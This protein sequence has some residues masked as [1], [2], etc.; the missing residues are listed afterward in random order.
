MRRLWRPRFCSNPAKTS[1]V[2]TGRGGYP[3]GVTRWWR[4]RFGADL[5]GELAQLAALLVVYKAVRFWS[6][7]H[8]SVAV[9]NARH[10]IRLEQRLRVSNE[11]DLTKVSMRL[12]ALVRFFNQY[13][14]LAHFA[15]TLV[16]M[17]WLYARRPDAYPLCRRI[18]I[19]MTA[20]GLVLHIAYPLAP[21]RMF[22]EF[23]FIDTGRL[24]GPR[25]YGAHGLFNGVSNQIAAMPSLHFG[26]ALLVGWG[27]I[28]F[29]KSKWRWLVAVHPVITLLAII[30]TANHYWLDAFV[31]LV[32]FTTCTS[33]AL[34][35][36]AIRARRAQD[37][38][39]E[40]Q[41]EHQHQRPLPGGSPT[42]QADHQWL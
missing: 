12:P 33:L 22:P 14:V 13:Y 4:S 27:A 30:I 3:S 41:H 9:D 16:F 21:P 5:L 40:H 36:E 25:A 17:I 1:G 8:F 23:G 6:R 2:I 37:H 11:F 35:R 38:Q 7:D 24:F 26:W 18:L 15:S 29:G 34:W 32:I 42:W 10:V 28:K 19:W 39:H 20:M 31:A